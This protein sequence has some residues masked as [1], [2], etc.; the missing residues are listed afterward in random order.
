MW[1]FYLFLA[2]LGIASGKTMQPEGFLRISL[3]EEALVIGKPRQTASWSMIP[4]VRICTSTGV[5]F[6]RASAAIRH[7]EN[8][9][10]SFGAVTV[11]PHV[12]CNEPKYGEIVITLPDTSYDASQMAS[13]RIYT[14]RQTNNIVKVKILILPQNA[15]KERVLEHEIGHALGWRHY[16][17]KY[18]IMNSTWQNG[19][20]NAYGIRRKY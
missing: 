16:N 15:R 3:F 17:Q 10:Y 19:G 20:Y 14:E 8:K 7:W 4:S 13:T 12:T 9:G 1:C 11:D 5:S 6:V 18:H 2:M